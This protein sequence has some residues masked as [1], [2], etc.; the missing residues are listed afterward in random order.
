M[1]WP[2]VA[3][4][5]DLVAALRS[6]R[7]FAVPRLF[8]EAMFLIRAFHG[9]LSSLIVCIVMPSAKQHK[10]GIVPANLDQPQ[11]ESTQSAQSGHSPLCSRVWNETVTPKR[12]KCVYRFPINVSAN[13]DR[14]R[15]VSRRLG[16]T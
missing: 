13:A 8:I 7:S 6:S 14:T 3:D 12:A 16:P 1:E 15:R 2:L 4:I 11:T 5:V 10:D 9:G